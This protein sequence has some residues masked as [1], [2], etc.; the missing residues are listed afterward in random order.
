MHAQPLPNPA[1]PQ[2]ALLGPTTRP[3]PGPYSA[4]LGPRGPTWPI[5]VARV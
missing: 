5:L 3:E 1:Q 2:P 4:P